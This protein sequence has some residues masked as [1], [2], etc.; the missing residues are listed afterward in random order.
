MSEIL[1]T[2]D[3]S[4]TRYWFLTIDNDALKKDTTSYEYVLSLIKQMF[5]SEFGWKRLGYTFKQINAKDGIS[6]R[7]KHTILTPWKKYIFHIRL[8]SN[9]FISKTCGFPGLSCADM[10]ENIIYLNDIN[11]VYGTRE[12]GM[13]PLNLRY[14]CINHEIGHL[15]GRHHKKCINKTECSIMLQQ[16]IK[17]DSC[18]CFSNIFPLNDD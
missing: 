1:S 17:K 6:L 15:L 7:N 4:F 10:S 2:G 9:K 3:T 8:S 18:H 14:Y 11:W 13:S 12:S 5:T 16:T